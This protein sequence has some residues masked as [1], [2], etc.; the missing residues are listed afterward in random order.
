MAPRSDRAGWM[1]ALR[2]GIEYL[3]WYNFNDRT[4]SVVNRSKNTAILYGD[5]DYTGPSA[6]I[7]PGNCSADV[8]VKHTRSPTGMES[9]GASGELD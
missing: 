5:C 8:A 7:R 4:S 9:S 6:V 3:D 1:L 2:G